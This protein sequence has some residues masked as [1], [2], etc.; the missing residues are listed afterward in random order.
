[1]RRLILIVNILLAAVLLCSCGDRDRPPSANYLSAIEAMTQS[2]RLTD[3]EGYLM[4]FTDA[5]RD[6]YR[7]SE[8]YDKD[9]AANITFDGEDTHLLQYS[10][11][12]YRELDADGIAK[13]KADHTAA[14]KRRIEVTKAYELDIE[15]TSDGK[16]ARRTLIVINNGV[17]W[18][19]CGDVIESIFG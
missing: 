2:V 15:F 8:T 12:E 9:V 4:C 16:T 13:I 18:Q 19:I 7:A 14:Y 5:A 3:T 17:G 1:M 11:E 10:V 6:K